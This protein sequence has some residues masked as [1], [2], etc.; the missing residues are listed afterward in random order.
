MQKRDILFCLVGGVL[1]FILFTLIGY[2][3]YTPDIYFEEIILI[4]IIGGSSIHVLSTTYK[5]RTIKNILLRTGLL[6]LFFLFF[7][8]INGHIGT[9][10][11]LDQCLGVVE[12]NASGRVSGLGQA[13]F[14][15]ILFCLS[16][17]VSAFILIG[18]KAR[19]RFRDKEGHGD[20]LREP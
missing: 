13:L 2:L 15:I 8:G 3:P 9:T 20:G 17:T 10:M 18:V 7:L 11:I 1:L 5:S 4:A 12:T 14:L 16:S 19:G 6:Y